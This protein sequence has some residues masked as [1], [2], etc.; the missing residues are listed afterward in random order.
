M[1]VHVHLTFCHSRCASF[2]II[3]IN[4]LKLTQNLMLHT[5]IC[6]YL[7]SRTLTFNVHT[8]Y[9]TLDTERCV[10]VCVCVHAIQR[11]IFAGFHSALLHFV[12]PIFMYTWEHA[13]RC[14]Y[15]YKRTAHMYF[16]SL[17]FMESQLT[18]KIGTLENFTL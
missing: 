5:H 14:T 1:S 10:C 7:T 2:H 6:L 4:N 8:Q 16:T 17:I 3:C 13:S 9:A 18:M 15:M 11:D 12:D